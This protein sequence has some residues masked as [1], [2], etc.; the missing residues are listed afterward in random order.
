MLSTI[1]KELGV[2]I[3][4]GSIP[5]IRD[6]KVYNTA[7]VFSP[8]GELVAKHAKVHLFDI[9]IPGKQS[10]RESDTLTAGS[11]VT[12]FDTP[13]CKVGL[14]ICYD[15]RFPQLAS[16]MRQEGCKMLIY[17]GA[18][19]TTT[20]PA[21]WELLLRARAVDNQCAVVAASPA[22]N[23]NSAYQAWGHST[24]V[25]PWGEIV[26]T[27]EHEPTNISAEIDLNRVD[28]VRQNVPISKQTRDDVYHD[29]RPVVA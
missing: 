27:C 9:D 24:I 18:F 13:W 8:E 12:T 26:A 28:E 16:L 1:A 25:S 17:P 15:V 19:N 14:A 23:P 6:G 10:F 11:S 20:G 22:R 2:Y 3:V 29:V 7:I 4:G 21:H 5:E